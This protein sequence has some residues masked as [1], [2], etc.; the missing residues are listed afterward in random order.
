Q[1]FYFTY[2]LNPL[3]AEG[4]DGSGQTI[5]ILVDSD[6]KTSDVD[7]YRTTLKLPP[8]NI[9]KV[10]SGT[11]IVNRGGVTELEALLD[12]Q[13]AGMAAPKATLQIVISDEEGI[14]DQP[15]AFA[16]NNLPETK[17]INI[18]Y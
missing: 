7:T 17:V 13:L 8:T 11:S 5:A 4:I 1:D 16:V 10:P 2:N 9:V 3:F 6:F 12:T 14:I 15:L 18:S